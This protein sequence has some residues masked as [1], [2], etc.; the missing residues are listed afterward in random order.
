LCNF[1]AHPYN[2]TAD[3]S[4]LAVPLVLKSSIDASKIKYPGRST[5]KEVYDAIIHDFKEA[6]KRLPEVI[7][8]KSSSYKGM[9]TLNA[10]KALLSRVYLYMGDWEDTKKMAADVISSGQY[11]L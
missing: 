6:I 4:H 3:A 2:Y 9:I 1:F 11:S 10:A 7:P 8:D 5:V